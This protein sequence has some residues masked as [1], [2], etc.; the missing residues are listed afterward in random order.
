MILASVDHRNIGQVAAKPRITQGTGR[1]A[2]PCEEWLGNQPSCLGG[3][4]DRYF[5]V[6]VD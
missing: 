6:G 5:A 3:S 4:R 1:I 2:R